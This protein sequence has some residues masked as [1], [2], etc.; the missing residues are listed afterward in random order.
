MVSSFGPS[1]TLDVDS[2]KENVIFLESIPNLRR[3]DSHG[4]LFR[5]SRQ[6]GASQADIQA[7]ANRG[8]RSYLDCRSTYE[9]RNI[10]NGRAKAIDGFVHVLVPDIPDPK[11]AKGYPSTS[12]IPVK[13]LSGKLVTDASPGTCPRRYLINMFSKEMALEIFHMAPWYKQIFTIL[14]VI[15]GIFVVGEPILHFTQCLAGEIQR[16]GLVGRYKGFLEYASKEICF[17]LKT[18]SDPENLPAMICCAH[19]KDRTGVVIALVLSVLGK[20]DE[21]I[22]GEYSLS[23]KGLEP[24]LIEQK[25]NLMQY[26]PDESFLLARKETML[27]VLDA[28]RKMYGSVENYLESIGFGR[29]DQNKLRLALA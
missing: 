22:A 11:A 15:I 8:I 10:D 29:E 18:L 17:I 23:E 16:F 14:W 21:Y 27:E 5:S 26:L 28:T 12:S 7:L 4:R 3:V 20:S 6:D 13:D 25:E 19:G 1:E 24:I 2:L 9:Y